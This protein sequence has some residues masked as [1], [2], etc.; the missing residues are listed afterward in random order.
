MKTS[1][2]VKQI[3]SRPERIQYDGMLKDYQLYGNSYKGKRYQMIY[4]KDPYSQQQTFLYKRAMFGLSMY[5]QKEIKE[6]HWQKRARI[7]K[8]HKRTQKVLNLWKQEKVN[9]LTNA[10]FA[11]FHHSP[12][13]K[14]LVEGSFVDLAYKSTM[15]FNELGIK[16]ADIIDR[17]YQEGILPN[18]FYKL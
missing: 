8:V 16:K 18:N 2:T 14:N 4:E 12:L 6:M 11:M 10:L 13:A 9:K 17:L 5:S 7:V 3:A 1:N 15:S